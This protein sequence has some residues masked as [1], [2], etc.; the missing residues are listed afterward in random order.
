MSM[1]LVDKQFLRSVADLVLNRPKLASEFFKEPDI[2][3]MDIFNPLRHL[4]D[5]LGEKNGNVSEDEILEQ[6]N[7]ISDKDTR[8]IF[9][10]ASSMAK[11][12]NKSY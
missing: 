5:L 8:E 3:K 2:V 11:R 9:I 4:I 6:I 1:T 7:K 10:S 12:K